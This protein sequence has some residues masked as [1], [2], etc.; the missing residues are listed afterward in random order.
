MY[1]TYFI[2]SRIMLGALVFSLTMCALPSYAGTSKS[3][4]CD[5]THAEVDPLVMEEVAPPITMFDMDGVVGLVGISINERGALLT[6]NFGERMGTTIK[7]ILG[8]DYHTHVKKVI[9]IA[10]DKTVYIDGEPKLYWGLKRSSGEFAIYARDGGVTLSV[11]GVIFYLEAE[12]NM[13]YIDRE[14]DSFLL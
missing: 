8:N 9:Y 6:G 2:C 5:L 11:N 7:L 1:L 10:P 3:V 12:F 13:V 4:I 14:F